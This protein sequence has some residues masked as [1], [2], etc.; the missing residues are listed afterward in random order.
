MMRALAIQSNLRSV[1]RL[2]PDENGETIDP[3][4]MSGDPLET[5]YQLCLSTPTWRGEEKR[6]F[7][8]ILRIGFHSSKVRRAW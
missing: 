4:S 2:F 3:R 6:L 1:G 8:E 7:E 5:G